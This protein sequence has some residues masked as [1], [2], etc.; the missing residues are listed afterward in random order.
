MFPALRRALAACSRPAFRLIQFSVQSNHLHLIVEA[1]DTVALSRGLQGLAVR[2]ARVINRCAPGGD[3][4]GPTAI[5][6]GR[7]QQPTEVRHALV[8]VLMN[9]K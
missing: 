6:R 1:D 5:T 8:Y 3:A 4:S 2:C 9:I 7:W